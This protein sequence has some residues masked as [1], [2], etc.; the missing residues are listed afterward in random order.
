MLR[1]TII[2]II[3]L[4]TQIS[5][6]QTYV[7]FPTSADTAIWFE[8]SYNSAFGSSYYNLATYGDTIFDGLTYTKIYSGTN[9]DYPGY[10]YA[11]IREE[12]KVI[13]VRDLANNN[14]LN[15]D[16]ILFDFNV[17]IGDTVNWFSYL[18]TNIGV[19]SIDSI[20]VA[21]GT[22]RKRFILGYQGGLEVIEGIGSNLGFIPEPMVGGGGTTTYCYF[23]NG[24]FVWSIYGGNES[25]CYTSTKQLNLNS[26]IKIFPNPTSD[27]LNIEFENTEQRE[28]MI[29]NQVGQ[30]VLNKISNETTVILNLEQ[31][32]KGFYVLTI[33]TQKGTFTKKII[34]H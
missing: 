2:L 6:A 4:L 15:A 24:D 20:Q 12:N 10:Y 33:R 25:N 3:S 30:Q 26:T 19:H 22:Y 32:P 7:P 21:D 1:F 31:L 18:G 29:F 5:N 8:S 16:T 27:N 28:L 23:L 14:N 17:Q 11:A 34:K 9:S 13:Y